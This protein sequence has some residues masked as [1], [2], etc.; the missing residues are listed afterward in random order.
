MLNTLSRAALRTRQQQLPVVYPQSDYDSSF[1]TVS[2]ALREPSQGLSPGVWCPTK[3]VPT[4]W[5]G[6]QIPEP[7]QPLALL[8][9]PLLSLC[10]HPAHSLRRVLLSFLIL[11]SHKGLQHPQSLHFFC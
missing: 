1:E 10:W 9:R 4:G 3:L 7:W 5:T 8:L 2:M 6:A 11:K